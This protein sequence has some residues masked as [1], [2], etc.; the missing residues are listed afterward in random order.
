M[1]DFLSEN[2]KAV[3]IVGSIL[4]VVIVALIVHG[5]MSGGATTDSQQD[6]TAYL[7]ND[8]ALP[9]TT[10]NISLADYP[11]LYDTVAG[12]LGLNEQNVSMVSNCGYYVFATKEDSSKIY[13]AYKVANEGDYGIDLYLPRF[14]TE[15]LEY[16]FKSESS[17]DQ[18]FDGVNS[19][20]DIKRI[21]EGDYIFYIATSSSIDDSGELYGLDITWLVNNSLPGTAQN[22]IEAGQGYPTSVIRKVCNLDDIKSSSNID[23]NDKFWDTVNYGAQI[24]CY[25]H[26]KSKYVIISPTIQKVAS[27]MDDIYSFT[28]NGNTLPMDE[29][30]LNAYL[31]KNGYESIDTA[32]TNHS[33]ANQSEIANAASI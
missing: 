20:S 18:F 30:S 4:A 15:P 26:D 11:M 31:T 2:K 5:A 19:D 23:F 13:F 3:I 24:K 32:L 16:N 21:D 9:D 27:G 28:V 33:Y 7:E 17:R 6:S 1:E 10:S 12:T 22:A 29:E 14:S 25:Y 8:F